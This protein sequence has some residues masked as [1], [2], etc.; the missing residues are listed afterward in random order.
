LNEINI[1]K[2]VPTLLATLVHLQG[3]KYVNLTVWPWPSGVEYLTFMIH[4]LNTI[5]S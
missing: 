2:A 1:F 3:T 4:V 5:K